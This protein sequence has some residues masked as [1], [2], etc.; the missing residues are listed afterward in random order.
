[1]PRLSI[2][3]VVAALTVACGERK[4]AAPPPDL[5]LPGLDHAWTVDELVTAAAAIDRA[6][7]ETPM[8]LPTHGT[9]AFSHLIAIDNLRAVPAAP[10]A[11]RQAELTRFTGAA[12]RLYDTYLR[13]GRPTETM[14][15]NAVLLEGYA[16]ALVVGA[17]MRDAAAADSPERAQRQHGLDTMVVGLRGGVTATVNMLTDASIPGPVP[18]TVAAR[19]GAAIA[20]VRA[21]VPPGTLDD[22]VA[23]LTAAA[24]AEPDPA[25]QQTLAAAAAA[26]R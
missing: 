21:Q 5:A 24:A 2:V 15:A 18:P 9:A 26:L 10:L 11:Q 7:T 3:L 17:A 13:C 20:Q 25:R 6:C 19:L 1:M 22:A 8:A 14:A 4:R 23:S 12:L 16:E